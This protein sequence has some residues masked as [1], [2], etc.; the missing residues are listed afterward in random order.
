M[1]W[2]NQDPIGFAGGMNWF[3]AFGN[4][5]I[6]FVDPL[7][8]CRDQMVYSSLTQPF[9]GMST[10]A[11]GYFG[12]FYSTTMDYNNIITDIVREQNPSFAR[13]SWI[14]RG[15]NSLGIVNQN[16]DRATLLGYE[17]VTAEYI[18][19]VEVIHGNYATKQRSY[20]WG[21]FT[22]TSRGDLINIA[23]TTIGHRYTYKDYH[24][25]LLP[26]PLDNVSQFGD[27]Q[28]IPIPPTPPP[29]SWYRQPR[30]YRYDS[31]LKQFFPIPESDLYKSGT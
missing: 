29:N 10:P 30:S 14:E 28:K 12:S 1:R 4:N 20:F 21:V 26:F 27:V 11:Q 13:A 6:S 16:G 15:S 2:L 19:N 25:S 18:W 22:S 23:N 24:S 8:L 9:P 17:R 31:D 3:A 5:P 7:G